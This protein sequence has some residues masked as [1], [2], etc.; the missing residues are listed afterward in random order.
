MQRAMS[1]NGPD[2]QKNRADHFT[3]IRIEGLLD[4]WEV[5]AA[6]PSLNLRQVAEHPRLV[7]HI[8]KQKPSIKANKHLFFLVDIRSPSFHSDEVRRSDRVS[9]FY[10]KRGPVAVP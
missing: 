3:V 2:G 4:Q 1:K 9:L 5:L 6:Q 7:L 8:G 10:F